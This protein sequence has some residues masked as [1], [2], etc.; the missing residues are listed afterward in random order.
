MFLFLTVE[1]IVESVQIIKERVQQSIEKQIDDAPVPQ[2]VAA[3][4]MD[5]W[6]ESVY[7]L[8]DDLHRLL[9]AERMELRREADAD[10]AE[11]AT[12]ELLR[13]EEVVAPKSKKAEK[14]Q[15]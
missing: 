14:G 1:E 7:S 10:S 9:M 6:V 3:T 4:D 12:A 11:R 15:R 8:H 2:I 13:E 5:A